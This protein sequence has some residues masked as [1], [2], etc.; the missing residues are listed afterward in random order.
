MIIRAFLFLLA[1]LTGVSAA[2]AAGNAHLAPSAIGSTTDSSTK[3]AALNVALGYEYRATSN[4]RPQTELS[5]FVEMQVYIPVPLI[6]PIASCTFRS[7][8]SRE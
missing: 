6:S 5:S 1:M 2:H 8:R 3:P 4:Y 7:D